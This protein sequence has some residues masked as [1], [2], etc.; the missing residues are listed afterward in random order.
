M[1]PN[2]ACSFRWPACSCSTAPLRSRLVEFAAM[3]RRV[4]DDLVD[5]RSRL[6]R[7]ERHVVLS[8]RPISTG[9]SVG[10]PA[11]LRSSLRAQRGCLMGSSGGHDGHETLSSAGD[12]RAIGSAAELGS[13]PVLPVGIPVERGCQRSRPLS[14]RLL[15]AKYRH[16]H[17]I[18]PAGHLPA[19][20]F[21]AGHRLWKIDSSILTETRADLTILDVR[22]EAFISFW[23]AHNEAIIQW[24]LFVIVACSTMLFFRAIFGKKTKSVGGGEE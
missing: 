23:M 8:E 13:A 16:L 6:E 3:R 7:R 17:A 20:D 1:F 9:S 11:R 10:R 15:F 4:R 14:G 2:P 21:P 12:R 18:S 19:V 24:V 22:F 5:R